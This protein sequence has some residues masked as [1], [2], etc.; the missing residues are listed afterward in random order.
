MS[1][2]L[3]ENILF[4]LEYFY[5]TTAMSTFK[6]LFFQQIQYFRKV[7]F[8]ALPCCLKNVDESSM[9]FLQMVVKKYQQDPRSFKCIFFSTN[10]KFCFAKSE[11]VKCNPPVGCRASVKTSYLIKLCQWVLQSAEVG[12]QFLNY[13]R[14]SHTTCH[15]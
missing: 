4:L 7:A 2:A 12:R 3:I 6:L 10:M 11:H 13:L 5:I 1:N 14:S 9:L 8:Q 15:L